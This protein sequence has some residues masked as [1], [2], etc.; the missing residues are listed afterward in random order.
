M[1]ITVDNMSGESWRITSEFLSQLFV[2]TQIWA[3]ASFDLAGDGTDITITDYNASY[4]TAL[5]PAQVT[6]GPTASF[7]GNAS[8]FF[9]TPDLSNPLFVLDFEYAGRFDALELSLVGL[10]GI[11]DEFSFGSLIL[12]QDS[13][14]NPGSLTWDVQ[15]IPGPATVALAPMTLIAARRRRSSP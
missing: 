7:V 15:Y 10:N 12:Y 1:L 14:G 2:P 4:D 11:V 5:G 8:S 3:S 9:G 6:N 13:L